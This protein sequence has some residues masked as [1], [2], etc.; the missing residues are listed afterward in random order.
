M[1]FVWLAIVLP[2]T[3]VFAYVALS[4]LFL[5]LRS[6]IQNPQSRLGPLLVVLIIISGYLLSFHQA[7]RF[8]W[9]DLVG[10][11]VSQILHQLGT[12]VLGAGS[13]APSLLSP[14]TAPIAMYEQKNDW[15]GPSTSVLLPII[16]K[17]AHLSH[18]VALFLGLF[19]SS[20]VTAMTNS[21]KKREIPQF[22]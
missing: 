22:M 5:L 11:F 6:G 3:L 9:K 20:Y 4:G 14:A 8:I 10:P 19:M 12:I 1:L 18:L 17:E 13:S 7:S 21:L 15:L 16:E 2:P